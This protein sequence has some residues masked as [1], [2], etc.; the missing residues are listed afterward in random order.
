MM[1]KREKAWSITKAC[2]SVVAIVVAA[3]WETNTPEGT[4]VEYYFY[5]NEPEFCILL[6]LSQEEEDF[7]EDEN[8][9]EK[10][11]LTVGWVSSPH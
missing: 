6:F 5:S 8:E 7:D 4:Y 9:E 11:L 10:K 3:E 1:P 2:Q